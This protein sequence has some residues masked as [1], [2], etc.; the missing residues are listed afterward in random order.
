MS[1]LWVEYELAAGY[2]TDTLIVQTLDYCI[3][4]KR[5]VS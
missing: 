2:G 3:I 4:G 1:W 5:T